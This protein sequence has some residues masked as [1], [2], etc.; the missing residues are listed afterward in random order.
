MDSGGITDKRVDI[1]GVRRPQLGVAYR[2]AILVTVITIRELCAEVFLN[3]CT[4]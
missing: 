2:E 1:M 3:C 4:L